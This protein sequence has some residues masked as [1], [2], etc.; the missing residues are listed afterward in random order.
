M[1]EQNAGQRAGRAAAA[2]G[3]FNR[4]LVA[5]VKPNGRGFASG[6]TFRAPGSSGDTSV[7]RTP[8]RGSPGSPGRRRLRLLVLLQQ[9]I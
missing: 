1:L 7:A 3:G 2:P 5:V 8:W 6:G 4:H 9:Q